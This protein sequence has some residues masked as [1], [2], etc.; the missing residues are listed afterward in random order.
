M[1]PIVIAAIITAIA[2][3]TAALI[4]R[5]KRE[6]YPQE[7][8]PPIDDGA[9]TQEPDIS[10]ESIVS[11]KQYYIGVLLIIICSILFGINHT[12]SRYIVNGYSSPF[13]AVMIRNTVSGLVI[14]STANLV[15]SFDQINKPKPI[16]F[17]RDSWLMVLGRSAS[18]L[19]YFLGLMYLSTVTAVTLYK[20]NPIFTFIILLF[21]MKTAL[22]NISFLNI[23]IGIFVSICGSLVSIAIFDLDFASDGLELVWGTV[24]ILCAAVFWSLYLVSAERDTYS[25]VKNIGFWRRQQYLGYIYLITA[26][27]FIIY[28]TYLT[29]FTDS[30]DTLFNISKKAFALL[31]LIGLI[32]GVIGILY[33][34]ALKRVSSLLGTVI[35]SLEIF[36]AM[37]F[38]LLFL[39]ENVGWNV[40]VGAVLV[41][42]GSVSI[43]RESD[44]L[45]K[46]I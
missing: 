21:I 25:S 3:I 30:I 10:K 20:L 31:V 35:I 5:Y 40:Y 39:G 27:P 19:F 41:I 7:K 6:A 14:L 37:I 9:E 23:M 15:R 8:E 38:A 43:G 13:I 1:D 33:F 17:T 42:I 45:K 34:E 36:F 24:F 28:S 2:T 12:L 18:G 16:K 44:K 32:S 29:I 46:I 26:V 22:P 4:H 11:D